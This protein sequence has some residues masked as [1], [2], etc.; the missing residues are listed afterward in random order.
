MTTHLIN[1]KPYQAL[2]GL[3]VKKTT[4]TLIMTPC[5]KKDK[6]FENP[7]AVDK[8]LKNLRNCVGN[9]LPFLHRPLVVLPHGV[10]L[11]RWSPQ[12]RDT[13]KKWLLT[14]ASRFSLSYKVV[15]LNLFASTALL[16]TFL[17]FNK[18]NF[19]HQGSEI[20]NIT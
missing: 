10:M 14:S 6:N 16:K 18:T 12:T 11:Q 3:K 5:T 2:K 13:T 4:L 15:Y 19:S 8:F 20:K 9:K 17:V 7:S 1:Y